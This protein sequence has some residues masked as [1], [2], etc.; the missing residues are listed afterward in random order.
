DLKEL[1]FEEGVKERTYKPILTS[2]P[3]YVRGMLEGLKGIKDKKPETFEE[4]ESFYV[5]I[6]KSLKAIQAIQLKQGKYMMHAFRNEMLKL[7]TALNKIIDETKKLEDEVVG[8]RDFIQ[9]RE[10]V[11]KNIAFLKEKLGGI[12]EE[13]EKAAKQRERA[14]ALDLEVERVEDVIQTLENSQQFK[15][16]LK[17]KEELAAISSAQKNL[18]GTILKSMSPLMRPFRKYQKS[19]EN[20]RSSVEKD[21]LEKLRKYQT[22]PKT[23]FASE[24]P[25]NL[26]LERILAG[27]E[28]A[29]KKGH[30]NLDKRERKKTLSRIEDLSSGQLKSMLMDLINSK[31][32]EESI[33]QRLSKSDV[34]ERREELIKEKES[35]KKERE[36]A[37]AAASQQPTQDKSLKTYKT[38][39]EKGMSKI[40]GRPV[41]VEVPELE[42]DQENGQDL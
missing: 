20:G 11:T 8:V 2:K 38:E 34:E 25:Q 42:G 5:G 9:E 10:V 18:E 4:L 31:K 36:E 23:A 17:M 39:I 27:L 26:I 13:K 35:Y 16:L 6:T 29:I 22:S 32:K 15:E 37:L 40:E 28:D 41:V 24:A 14:K 30:I 12:D 19:V 1:E 21:V 33:L 7:G 3:V